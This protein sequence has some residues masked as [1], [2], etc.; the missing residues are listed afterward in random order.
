MTEKNIFAFKD[1]D[2]EILSSNPFFEAHAPLPPTPTPAEK[3][4]G[5]GAHYVNK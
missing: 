1:W 2:P 3:K 5:G 4:G